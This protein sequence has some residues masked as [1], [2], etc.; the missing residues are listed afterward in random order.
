MFRS[1]LYPESFPTPLRKFTY[2]AIWILSRAKWLADKTTLPLRSR[3]WPLY[4]DIHVISLLR[5]RSVPNLRNPRSLNDQIRWT[6]LFAQDPK[7]PELCDK[8]AVR[9]YV[10]D[11]IGE[12]YLVPL[13]AHGSW[14]EV[15]S[16]LPG[17]KG[18]LKCTHDSGSALL[19]DFPTKAKMADIGE[20]FRVLLSKEY[21]VGKGEWPYGLVSPKLIFEELLPGTENGVSPPDVKVHC[22]NGEPALYEVIMERQLQP[23]G[24][25]FLPDGSQLKEHI[26]ADRIT[27][28]GF[29]IEQAITLSESPARKLASGL[30]YVRVDFYLA[31][32]SVFFGEMTFFPESGL[33]TPPRGVNTSEILSLPCADPNS[34]VYD[35]RTKT[36]L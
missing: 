3:D 12:S 25:L 36:L 24:S 26:R 7:M 2:A 11:R 30:K 6:M 17:Q 35:S 33:F 5:L 9:N 27:L 1:G 4:L 34:S 31:N 14:D 8:L 32:N 28:E 10:R 22:V 29:P 21:G 13:I 19:V 20:R 18:F 23:R 16:F 15:A